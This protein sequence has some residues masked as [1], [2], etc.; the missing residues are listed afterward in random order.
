M[1]VAESAQVEGLADAGRW[2][3]WQSA[4]AESIRRTATRVQ[5]IFVILFAAIVAAFVMLAAL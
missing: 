5:V 3:F 4:Y 2:R 1:N